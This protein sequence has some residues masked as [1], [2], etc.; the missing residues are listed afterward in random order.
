MSV[1]KVPKVDL[2]C[3]VQLLD[4][5]LCSEAYV[6]SVLALL[7]EPISRPMNIDSPNPAKH[8]MSKLA[9]AHHIYCASFG[10][11]DILS[12]SIS[13]PTLRLG[14]SRHTSP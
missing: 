7:V 6:L 11:A 1:R 10:I 8:K 3:F 14:M 13:A 12:R 5:C 9:V 4:G 2:V